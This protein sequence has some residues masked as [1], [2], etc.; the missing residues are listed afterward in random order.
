MSRVALV[1]VYVM[2]GAGSALQVLMLR[3]AAGAKRA[4]TWECVHGK[5]DADE[6]AA[7]A[8]W[9]ELREETGC[10]AAALYNLSRV[11]SFYLHRSDEVVEI[12]VFAAFLA[13]DAMVQLSEEHDMVRWLPPGEARPLWS[14]PRA[15]RAID[16]AVRLLGGGD[17]GLLES[18]LRVG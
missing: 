4:G 13:P 10:E 8:A 14:W 17:A 3:R 16:D 15:V 7:E 9:R 6:S 12:P 2:R 5:I 1:D 11:E 18:V